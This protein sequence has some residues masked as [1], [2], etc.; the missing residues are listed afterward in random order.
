M[1]NSKNSEETTRRFAICSRQR[2]KDFAFAL[3]AAGCKD[4]KNEQQHNDAFITVVD[5]VNAKDAVE[6]KLLDSEL[7]EMG[8]NASHVRVFPCCS[9]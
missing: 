5:A 6:N 9:R 7:R 1:T 8:Y 2:Y 4:L 3:H